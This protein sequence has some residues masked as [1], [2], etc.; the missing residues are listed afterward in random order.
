MPA[1]CYTFFHPCPRKRFPAAQEIFFAGFCI[2]LACGN[3]NIVCGIRE[4]VQIVVILPADCKLFGSF[5][6][7]VQGGLVC[8][9]CGIGL[10]PCVFVRDTLKQYRPSLQQTDR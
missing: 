6:Q 2:Y 8:R 5:I 7:F 3:G 10:F 9:P 4:A 1:S